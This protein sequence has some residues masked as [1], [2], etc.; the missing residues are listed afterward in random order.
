MKDDGELVFNLGDENAKPYLDEMLAEMKKT[1][2]RNAFA[3]VKDKQK[4]L[5]AIWRAIHE[6]GKV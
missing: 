5:L 3:A 1:D 2:A 4:E 6:P